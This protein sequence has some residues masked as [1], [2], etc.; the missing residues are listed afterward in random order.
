MDHHR[1]R[2]NVNRW[3]QHLTKAFPVSQAELVD[4]YR[5]EAESPNL[6][7]M[8]PTGWSVLA[9]YQAIWKKLRDEAI[10]RMIYNLHVGLEDARYEVEK[11]IAAL[12]A[13][14]HMTNVS[15]QDDL[16][17]LVLPLATVTF[18]SSDENDVPD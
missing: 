2:L 15:H 8:E 9:A 12:Q 3:D 13:A 5:A 4:Q 6:S 10:S 11:N 1:G 14:G 17:E 7:A 18:H 16:E